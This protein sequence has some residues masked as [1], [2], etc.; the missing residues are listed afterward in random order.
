MWYSI[1]N[2]LDYRENI[3]NT[4]RIKMAKSL[5]GLT[6]SKISKIDFDIDQDSEWDNI[7]VCYPFILQKEN[8]LIMFY[9][10]N[11]FGKT[12]IGYAI[13]E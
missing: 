1:R 6:W 9:N 7:M 8:K 10:G 13:K 11:G 12:G 4:Y 2:K 3:E 5:D